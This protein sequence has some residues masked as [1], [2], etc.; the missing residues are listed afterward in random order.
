MAHCWCEQ[1]QNHMCAMGQSFNHVY[2]PDKHLLQDNTVGAS[3]PLTFIVSCQRQFTK[4]IHL[5]SH[6]QDSIPQNFHPLQQ[7]FYTLSL[8]PSEKWRNSILITLFSQQGA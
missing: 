6:A 5:L 3:L 8:L 4:Y 7:D 2:I 1:A